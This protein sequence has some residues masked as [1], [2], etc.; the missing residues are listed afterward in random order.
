VQGCTACQSRLTDLRA[1]SAAMQA[2]LTHRAEGVD[3]SGFAQKVMAQVK[4][5]PLP[6]GQRLRVAWGELMAYHSAAIYSAF[7]AA[8][9]ATVVMGVVL[10]RP[11]GMGD[12]DDNSLVVHSLSVSD[13]RYEPV[14]MHTDDGKTMIM[15]VEHNPAEDDEAADTATDGAKKDPKA[16]KDGKALPEPTTTGADRP[17]GGDL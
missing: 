17:R 7:G 2:Y 6:L 16:A 3:F 11:A 14:V 10:V 4:K 1:T 12:P 8:A 15:L 13:P 9:V 5:E